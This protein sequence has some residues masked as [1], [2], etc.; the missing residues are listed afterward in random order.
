MKRKKIEHPYVEPQVEDAQ[1][2]EFD[3][4]AESNEFSKLNQ[5]FDKVNNAA[6]RAEISN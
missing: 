2:I 4:Q 6:K 1:T 3:T 5:E